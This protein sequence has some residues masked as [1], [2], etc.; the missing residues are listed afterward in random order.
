MGYKRKYRKGERITSLDE[1]SKQEFVYFFDKITHKGWFRSWQIQLAIRYI[2]RGW[3]Y[4][5]VKVGE[6]K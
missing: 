1:L 4:Y 6:T 5:A 3:L 2:D